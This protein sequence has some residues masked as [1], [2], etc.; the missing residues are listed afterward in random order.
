MPQKCLTDQQLI[1]FHPAKHSYSILP[2]TLIQM[3][4]NKTGKII[5]L[6]LRIKSAH[7]SC[8]QDPGG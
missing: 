6:K 8:L 4:A 1:K 2:P 3:V 5:F 7:Q